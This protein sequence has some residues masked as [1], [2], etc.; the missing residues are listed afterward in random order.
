MHLFHI[1]VKLYIIILSRFTIE[2]PWKLKV[3][4]APCSFLSKLQ[5]LIPRMGRKSNLFPGFKSLDECSVCEAKVI[6]YK[7][8]TVIIIKKTKHL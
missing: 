5:C 6:V 2:M 3:L 4:E 1:K 7:E 8:V